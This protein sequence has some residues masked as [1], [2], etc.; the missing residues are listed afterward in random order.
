MM[1]RL[2]DLVLGIILLLLLSPI[3]LIVALAVLL[4]LGSPVFFRQTRPGLNGVPFI[5]IKF[6]T[7]STTQDSDRSVASDEKRLGRTGRFLRK[8][9]L[10]ELPELLNI[11]RGDMS[12][13]GPRPLLMEYLPLYSAEQ[14]GRH[15][16]KPGLTGWAQVNGRNTLS[17]DERF[18]L[19][20]W[21]V[22]NQS[23]LLD[24]KIMLMTI[25][26]V[27]GSKGIVQE[28]HATMEPFRGKRE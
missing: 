23:F 12:F 17:W 18:E 21:Y 27:L 20:N 26:K 1:K 7:M 13:V 3:I 15:R 24:L 28:G 11:V 10:D 22:E 5:L 2:I 19:D 14:A 9:S 6:R 4:S 8:F 16:V 25:P